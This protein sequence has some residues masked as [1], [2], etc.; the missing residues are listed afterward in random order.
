MKSSAAPKRPYRLG[1]R[2]LAAEDTARRILDAFKGRIREDWYDQITLEQIAREA[3]VTVPTIIRRFGSKEKLMEDAFVGLSEEITE[4]RTVMPGDAA[5]AAR[6][7]VDDY[8]VVGDLVMRSLAQEDR[9]PAIKAVNDHGRR[10]HRSWV[11][12]SFAPQLEGLAPAARKQ[13]LDALVAAT[14]IYVWKLVRRDMG[15]SPQHVR[16]VMLQLI[17]GALVS[18]KGECK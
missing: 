10:F 6:V 5:G 18:R 14:D 11:E 17:E 1:V 12:A 9:Y 16:A 15:R 7:V 3:E 8:E 4:R 13:R 2:A